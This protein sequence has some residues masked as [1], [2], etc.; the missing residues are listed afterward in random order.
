MLLSYVHQWNLQSILKAAHYKRYVCPLHFAF[1]FLCFKKMAPTLF[2]SKSTPKLPKVPV[3]DEAKANVEQDAT[4]AFQMASSSIINHISNDDEDTSQP[5]T[6]QESPVKS[7]TKRISSFFKRKT[8]ATPTPAHSNTTTV[9]TPVEAAVDHAVNTIKEN[10]STLPTPVPS[11]VVS[12]VDN[13]ADNLKQ[14][15]THQTQAVQASAENLATAQVDSIVST[16]IIN[17]ILG[18]DAAKGVANAAEKVA[19][20][21]PAPTQPFFNKLNRRLSTIFSHGPKLHQHIDTASSSS[22]KV[23]SDDASS[24]PAPVT[25]AVAVDAAPTP[26]ETI[27]PTVTETE[28]IASTEDEIPAITQE[29]VKVAEDTKEV[30]ESVKEEANIKSSSTNPAFFKRLNRRMSSVFV[31]SPKEGNTVSETVASGKL[32]SFHHWYPHPSKCYI[33]SLSKQPLK[34]S[35]KPL[36]PP[37]KLSTAPLQLSKRKPLRLFNQLN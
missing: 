2:K 1:I 10:A 4:K 12:Q 24:T 8:P 29:A 6:A 22:S 36:N 35:H 26:A 30:V 17:N 37:Q 3:S 5:S 21:T 25:A 33:L 32:F 18:S 23:P 20:K 13:L 19:E 28:A 9:T 27:E 16:E 11:S 34:V 14:E 7:L 15:A 31:F